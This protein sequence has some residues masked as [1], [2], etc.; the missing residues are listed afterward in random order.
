MEVERS[1]D[2]IQFEKI[3]AEKARGDGNSL[4]LQTY[5]FIDA[6]PLPGANYYRL[7]QVDKDNKDEYHKIIT[8]LFTDAKSDDIKVFPTI[9]REELNIA[10]SKETET[11]GQLY[12]HNAAGQLVWRGTFERGMQQRTLPL[13]EL[14]QGQYFITLQTSRVLQ[15]ARF[16]K[17]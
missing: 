5:N 11:D 6:E 16:V 14:P 12:I 15:T 13:Q 8:V 7:R 17:M 10:L 9:V 1:R 4:E 2:G 3:G